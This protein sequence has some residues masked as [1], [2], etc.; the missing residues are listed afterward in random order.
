MGE[1][2][3]GKFFIR[4]GNEGFQNRQSGVFDKL[5]MLEE[6]HSV[7]VSTWKNDDEP[8]EE[9]DENENDNEEDGVCTTTSA[10]SNSEIDI[11]SKNKN[12]EPFKV[13][14]G[15]PPKRISRQA[16]SSDSCPSYRI[17]PEKWT[18]YTLSNVTEES[19]SEDANSEA[20]MEFLTSRW[21]TCNDYEDEDG[22]DDQDMASSGEENSPSSSTMLEFGK[23][24]MPEYTVGKFAGRQSHRSSKRSKRNDA[25]KNGTKGAGTEGKNPSRVKLSFLNSISHIQNADSSGVGVVGHSTCHSTVERDALLDDEDKPP[26]SPTA[27]AESDNVQLNAPFRSIRKRKRNI[28]QATFDHGEEDGSDN[29]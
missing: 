10:C 22:K 6:S 7:A 23:L 8:E 4:S 14:I 12:S 29:K 20:A 5:N 11:D 2:T 1:V 9:D 24:L 27:E 18:K 3:E 28:R 21:K 26:S 16:A 13:P 19:L 25:D 17:H 15:F